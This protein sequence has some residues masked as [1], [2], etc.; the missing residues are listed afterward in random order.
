MVKFLNNSSAK[1]GGI[2]IRNVPICNGMAKKANITNIKNI[3]D[4]LE[5]FIFSNTIYELYELAQN[6]DIFI[7]KYNFSL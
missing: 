2:R 3:Q 1:C 6:I 4:P 7:N 5:H